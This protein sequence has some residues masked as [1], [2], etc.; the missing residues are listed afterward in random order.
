M[1]F[2]EENSGIEW[3]DVRPKVLSDPRLRAVKIDLLRDAWF[4]TYKY[5]NVSIK[6]QILSFILN[7]Y[8]QKHR[9]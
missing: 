7:K 6:T 5:E 9:F 8:K 2:L 1:K 4:T 3:K